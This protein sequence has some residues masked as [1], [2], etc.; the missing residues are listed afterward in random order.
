MHVQYV[1]VSVYVSLQLTV[2]P[3]KESSNIYADVPVDPQASLGHMASMK[4]DG[5]CV[6]R[7]AEEG[8]KDGGGMEEGWRRDG[9]GMEGHVWHELCKQLLKYVCLWMC[10]CMCLH[11]RL[12]EI[13]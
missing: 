12:Q 1:C 2:Q 4:K 9:G 3:F 5:A 13:G 7:K 11:Q 8:G 6:W 10:V